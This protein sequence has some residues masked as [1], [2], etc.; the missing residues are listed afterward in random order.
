[1]AKSMATSDELGFQAAR[2]D[3]TDSSMSETRSSSKPSTSPSPHTG[4]M[5]SGI[6]TSKVARI[7]VE[8]PLRA[9]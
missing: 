7:F 3:L 9:A 5:P 1:M 4:I 6:S 2:L 8:R